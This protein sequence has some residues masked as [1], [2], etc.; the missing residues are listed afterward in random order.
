MN[1]K[2]QHLLLVISFC[3]AKFYAPRGCMCVDAQRSLLCV[4]QH[5]AAPCRYI[6]IKQSRMTVTRGGGWCSISVIATR[7]M[8]MQTARNGHLTLFSSTSV[9]CSPRNHPIACAGVCVDMSLC[10]TLNFTLLNWRA[11]CGVHP[12]ANKDMETYLSTALGDD[13]QAADLAKRMSS[14]GVALSD[15]SDLDEDHLIV[16]QR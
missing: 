11:S 10:G 7:S 8:C 9:G 12:R 16:S 5:V 6:T 15:L 4:S 13:A 1:D 14:E 3:S 2:I